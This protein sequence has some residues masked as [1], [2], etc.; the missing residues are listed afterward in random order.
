MH[1]QIQR[2]LI[3]HPEFIPTRDAVRIGSAGLETV[4]AD[5]YWLQTIQYIG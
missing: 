1:K 2:N 3:D 5:I 4:V